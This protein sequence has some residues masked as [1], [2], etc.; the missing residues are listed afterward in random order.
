MNIID[1]HQKP[2]TTAEKAGEILAFY[3]VVMMVKNH[4]K[5][6]DAKTKMWWETENPHIGRATPIWYYHS[7]PEKCVAWIT[8]MIEAGA[9]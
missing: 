2:I 4:M 3:D 5:W 9:I 7:R 6:D 1:D 8:S